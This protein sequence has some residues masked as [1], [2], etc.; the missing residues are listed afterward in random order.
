[1][2]TQ[3]LLTPESVQLVGGLDFVT[4]RPTVA[5]G[6]LIDC[7]NFEVAD[8]LGYKRVDGIEKFDGRP[9][10]SQAYTSLYTMEIRNPS[11]TVST[12]VYLGYEL[13]SGQPVDDVMKNAFGYVVNV[14]IKDETHVILDFVI[15]N[16]ASFRDFIE[17]YSSNLLYFGKGATGYLDTYVGEYSWARSSTGFITPTSISTVKDSI[18]GVVSVN[19]ELQAL[20]N[21]AVTKN[22][23]T[24]GQV[25]PNGAIG[26]HWFNDQLYS[27]IDLDLI[28]FDTGTIEI[29]PNDYCFAASGDGFTVRAVRVLSGTWDGGDALG[30]LQISRATTAPQT[31][32]NYAPHG[33]TSITRGAST[34]S[35]AF[36]IPTSA[37]SSPYYPWVA[38]L[39]RTLTIDDVRD[40][41]GTIDNSAW[42]SVELGYNFTYKDGTSNGPPSSV[43]RTATPS[44]TS[45]TYTPVST[46][47]GVAIS[48]GTTATS[49][50]TGVGMVYVGSSPQEAVSS[51]NDGH[52]IYPTATNVSPATATGSPI[53]FSGFSFNGIADGSI[54]VDAI[55]NLNCFCNFNAAAK[56]FKLNVSLSIDGVN[57]SNVQTTDRITS[58]S[59][60][61]TQQFTFGGPTAP[62]VIPGATVDNINNLTAKVTVSGSG[63]NCL[64]YI[65]YL[66]VSVSYQKNY[67]IYFFN[68]GTDDVQAVITN[69]YLDPSTNGDWST[70]DAS[71]TM[72][73]VS[74]KPV[75]LEPPS[76]VTVSTS[77]S[78]GSLPAATQYFY[79]V[80]ALGTVGETLVSREV[81]ITTGAGASNKNTIGWTASPNAVSYNIYRGPA[82]GTEIQ[83]TVLGNVTTFNDTGSGWS[84]GTL[85]TS[86]TATITTRTNIRS[87]DKIYTLPNA[88]G[89]LIATVASDMQFSGL[90][91]KADIE[92]NSSRY[93]IIDANFYGNP[94]WAAIYGVSGAG[95]AWTYD[96][97]YFRYIFT[98]LA[99]IVDK[100]R[101]V[102]FYNFHLCLGYNTGALLTSV[103][104]EPEN[105]D[106]VFGA[107]EFDTG[108]FITGLL[109]LNGTSL[110]IFCRKSIQILN[111]TDNSNF[112][113]STFN[114]YEGA[115]E[116]T[117]I[118]CGKPVWCSYRGIST[119]DQS[120]AYGNFL[121]TRLSSNINPWLLPRLTSNRVWS[122]VEQI[123]LSVQPPI[124]VSSGVL[125][126]LPVRNKNQYKLA[127]GDGYW[128]T[129]TLQGAGFTPTFTIQQLYTNSSSGDTTVMVPLAI[130]S[131]I[132]SNGN[133]RNHFSVDRN[134]A[135]P[136]SE[137]SS[138]NS[139]HLY[140]W[141]LDRG[142]AFGTTPIK[143]W[144]TTTHNFFDNPFQMATIR[145]TRL[146]GLSFGEATLS[147]AAS[148]DYLSN[149]FKYGDLSGQQATNAPA[150]DISL[151]R[152]GGSNPW[153]QRVAEYKPQ[154][155]IAAFGKTGRSFSF[156]FSTDPSSVE[157]PCVLQQL[158]FQISTGKADIK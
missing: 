52:Y 143:G 1:M 61:A 40:S 154:T 126:A 138:Q 72:Q 6:S 128:L 158:L 60:G 151:P 155:N 36:N 44:F 124:P 24:S 152:D 123:Q 75:L 62:W 54:I 65:D 83:V 153:E 99:D 67:G 78:G 91:C 68:N 131:G 12:L 22:I 85:P 5:P 116:Y 15:T 125:F 37:A 134:T 63:T 10:A 146:H 104:G 132:D 59:S 97:N 41:Y 51:A 117:V 71:G 45:K 115:I 87:G 101:H 80:T 55:V 38:G 18:D 148:A 129:M 76:N 95:R 28:P 84:S 23:W 150:Q 114:P 47:S 14:T 77:T 140:L 121:G 4:P 33:A 109:R 8:R 111:G 56:I 2:P 137:G 118:D 144:F 42:E 66:D 90:A 119:L 157:P 149:D 106:G 30:W 102:V 50:S 70:N 81:S 110:G 31:S 92:A 19:S 3:N 39:Y 107:G 64:V 98:G 145:N 100:P 43:E 16:A 103:A 133:D 120:A 57:Y 147:V 17:T 20:V 142:W 11:T 25:N 32:I 13:Y 27:V 122:K 9:S 73:V 49:Y 48:K 135:Y 29:L 112:S 34:T 88:G 79:V 21:P 82:T 93:E 58:T 26:L 96:G 46:A 74:V 69:V 105:F 156:Q 113:I 108:D 136:L 139:D 141:E 7:Y 35:S 127:F 130:S 89:S 86:N 94:D 53:T